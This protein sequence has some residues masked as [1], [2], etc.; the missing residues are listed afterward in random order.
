MTIL[1]LEVLQQRVAESDLGKDWINDSDM[2]QDSWSIMALGYSEE[3]CH[4]Y[5]LQNIHFNNFSLPWLKFLTKLTAKTIA[6]E[7]LSIGTLISRIRILSNLDNFLVS[8]GYIHPEELTEKILHQFI[9]DS[10]GNHRRVTLMYALNLWAEERWLQVSWIPPRSKTFVPKIETIPEEVLY[11]IYEKFDLLPPPLERLFRLQLV[12]GSRI[13]EMLMMPYQCLKQ[14]GNQW[15]LLRWIEKRQHWQFYRVHPLV[16]ELIQ[17]QQ[18]FLDE[19]FG[20][21]TNFDKLFCKVLLQKGAGRKKFVTTPIYKPEILSSQTILSWLRSFSEEAN[22]KDKHGDKFYVRSHMF[23]RTKASIMAYCEAEDEYIAAMLGH[24]SLDML[25]HYRKRSL[26]RLEK[27]T[28]AKA[29]VDM[30]GQVT[31]FKPRKP[32][33]A[34][35]AELLKVSTPLGEC[36]RPTMLGDCQY[37]YACLSCSHHRVTLDDK[38]KLEADLK[39]LQQDL[40]QAQSAGQERRVTEIYRLLNLLSNRLQGLNQLPDKKFVI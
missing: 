28:T 21:D 34:R 16:V 29:Y 5:S 27:D 20:Q 38:P 10:N 4:I 36:H 7:Q 26:A 30:Y 14:E 3:I 32:R 11:Q 13:G 22:L 12:L 15:F 6:K 31:T 39:L 40:E 1:S 18:R 23:R 8:N 37:R 9:A 35:L 33:Y 25:P 24:S 17:E 2:F 19:Q